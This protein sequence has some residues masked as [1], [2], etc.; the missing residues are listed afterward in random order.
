LVRNW[1]RKQ[2][3]LSSSEIILNNA[4]TLL[5]DAKILRTNRRYASALGLAVLSLEELGKFVILT[6]L[7]DFSNPH[8]AAR[9]HKAKQR[10]AARVVI[11]T[12][13]MSEVE[14]LVDLRDYELKDIVGVLHGEKQPDEKD[15]IDV[16]AEFTDQE[17]N[18]IKANL[19][20]KN[21]NMIII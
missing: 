19:Y 2:A 11:G 12:M 7:R 8:D 16:F 1:L 14:N 4:K 13:L 17:Y 3:V 18:T 5:D 6:G 20:G 10:T 9:F 21:Q 15:L